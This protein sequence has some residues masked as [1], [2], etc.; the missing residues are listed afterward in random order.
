M[1]TDFGKIAHLTQTVGEELSPLQQ[2]LARVTRTIKV[3]LLESKQKRCA[4][5]Q[6][7]IDELQLKNAAVLCGRAE[8][9]ALPPHR[10]AYDRALAR[11]VAPLNQLAEYLLPYVRVGGKALCWKGP[12]VQTETAAGGAAATRL[13]WP[14]ERA[15]STGDHA[16]ASPA[17]HDSSVAPPVIRRVSTKPIHAV[18]TTVAR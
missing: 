12:A 18:S 17:S 9:L 16:K 11:A 15:T 14:V 10:E 4:F 8:D 2:E 3:S 5:L 13:K 1:N 6:A 7:V